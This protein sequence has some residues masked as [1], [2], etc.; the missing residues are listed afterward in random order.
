MK[1]VYILL[2]VI[3]ALL[4][5]FLVLRLV[6]RIKAV[7]ACNQI[8]K[9]T[10]SC[11]EKATAIL[12][13][14]FRRDQLISDADLPLEDGTGLYCENILVCRGGI[15]V[16]SAIDFVGS[17]DDPA[18]G[19]WTGYANGQAVLLD[20]PI[21]QNRARLRAIEN[22][23]RREEIDN[24]PLRSTVVLPSKETKLKYRRDEIIRVGQLFEKMSDMNKNRFLSS[25]EMKK[26]ISAIKKNLAVK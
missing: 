6:K 9:M 25:H 24:I 4:I 13:C 16:I 14:E 26:V 3:G 2:S 7:K 12:S 22:I 8:L 15:N 1:I 23:L 19:N 21:E 20:N 17:I 5:I 18:E 10:C 11:K